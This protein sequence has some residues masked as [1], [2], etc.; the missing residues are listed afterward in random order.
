MLPETKDGRGLFSSLREHHSRWRQWTLEFN[1]GDMD[2][3]KARA[4][5]A[6][7]LEADLAGL[8]EQVEWMHSEGMLTPAQLEAAQNC[9]GWGAQLLATIPEAER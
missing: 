2:L 7:A 8:R 3:L 6:L 9:F 1:H 4:V 5:R